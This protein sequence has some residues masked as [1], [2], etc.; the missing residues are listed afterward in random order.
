MPQSVCHRARRFAVLLGLYV[1][2][3]LAY[4]YYK[5]I[6]EPN[7]ERRFKLHGEI[8]TG[9]AAYQFRYRVLIPNV[10][11]YLARTIQQLP[12]VN[13]SPIHPPA[14]YSQRAFNLAYFTLNAAGLG[15]FFFSL[16]RLTCTYY[17]ATSAALAVALSA[18][19]VGLTFRDHYF[20]PWS[21]WEPAFY[22]IGMLMVLRRSYGLFTLLNIIAVLTR[23]TTAFLPLGFLL[24][25][26]PENW[27]HVR[28]GVLATRPVRV[29]LANLILWCGTYFGLHWLVGYRAP[30]F[31]LHDAITGNFGGLGHTLRMTILFLGPLWWVAARQMRSAP[32]LFRRFGLALIPYV[33]VLFVIGLWWEIRYWITILPVLSP[34]IVSALDREGVSAPPQQPSTVHG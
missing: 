13:R 27:S 25:V 8:V 10:A 30:T 9:E 16:W 31:F 4:E 12:P 5:R 28:V 1:T 32:L 15:L 29:A 18:F 33:A 14:R 6:E 2:F 7:F 17:G 11:E 21:F 22:G 24:Y 23:E 20:H 3:G 19:A 26:L 34:A